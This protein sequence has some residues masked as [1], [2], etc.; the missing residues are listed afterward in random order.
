M[1]VSFLFSFVIMG[2]FLPYGI[3]HLMLKAF[4]ITRR[5]RRLWRIR[6]RQQEF[7]NWLAADEIWELVD[8]VNV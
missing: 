4:V 1:H 3:K 7:L 8:D 2:C 5:A 6:G